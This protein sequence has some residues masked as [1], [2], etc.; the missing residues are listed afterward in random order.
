MR[1]LRK[2]DYDESLYYV[3]SNLRI[4]KRSTHGLA[5]LCKTAG[6][7]EKLR[8]GSRLGCIGKKSEYCGTAAGH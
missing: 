8:A 1:L 3:R 2:Q 5:D 7:P 4:N 6:V